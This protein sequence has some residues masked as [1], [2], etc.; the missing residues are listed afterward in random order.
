MASTVSDSGK[1][2]RTESINVPRIVVPIIIR[3]NHNCCE[4][5]KMMGNHNSCVLGFLT[6]HILNVN[7]SLLSSWGKIIR[8]LLFIIHALSGQAKALFWGASDESK[9][10]RSL[11]I[12]I[13]VPFGDWKE[14]PRRFLQHTQSP[15]FLHNRVFI[16]RQAEVK[17][18]GKPLEYAFPK[19]T[20]NT[21]LCPKSGQIFR[22]I[23]QKNWIERLFFPTM[24]PSANRRWPLRPF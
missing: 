24:K 22:K 7:W 2:G 19:P 23:S 5:N 8:G 10:G 14:T 1:N 9:W 21:N 3:R 11:R 16:N 13:Y 12:M 4:D 20:E 17:V 18:V 6:L 15:A